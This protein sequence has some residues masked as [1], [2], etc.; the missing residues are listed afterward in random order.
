MT[1]NVP[2]NDEAKSFA[3]IVKIMNQQL[4][5]SPEEIMDELLEATP[6]TIREILEAGRKREDELLAEFD[7]KG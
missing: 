2:E 3:D 4:G 7:D 1:S 5:A 6:R